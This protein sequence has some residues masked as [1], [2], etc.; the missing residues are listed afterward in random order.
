MKKL[1]A[2]VSFAIALAISGNAVAQ[3]KPSVAKYV[4]DGYEIVRAEFGGQFLQFILKKDKTVVWCSVL[5]QDG[6]TSS[7]RTIQ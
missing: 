1:F 2:S 3:D 6:K 4:A 5:V 7:C